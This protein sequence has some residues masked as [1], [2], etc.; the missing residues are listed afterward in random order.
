MRWFRRRYLL[1]FLLLLATTVW[2]SCGTN[3]N[4]A[5][6]DA[7]GW[8]NPTALRD[9][10]ISAIP[11]H[12]EFDN[13]EGDEQYVTSRIYGIVA[14][15]KN[16]NAGPLAHRKFL[17]RIYVDRE[18][19]GLKANVW[20]YWVAVDTSR[21]ATGKWVSAWVVRTGNHPLVLRE[22]TVVS[23]GHGHPHTRARWQNNSA[24]VPWATC[25]PNMCCCEGPDCNDLRAWLL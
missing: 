3:S 11:P 23:P 22:L 12:S 19:R 5:S 16:A 10:I 9:S 1:L 14:P 24:A 18:Y 21:A 20:N 2:W 8:I 15:H 25:S 13:F 4:V 7:P 17:G 6:L